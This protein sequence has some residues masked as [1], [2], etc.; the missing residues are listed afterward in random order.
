MCP[1]NFIGSVR[2]KRD[3]SFE[4][5][6]CPLPVSLS[7]FSTVTHVSDLIRERYFTKECFSENRGLCV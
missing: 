1:D 6:K 5:A 3:S 4:K 2:V 7:S